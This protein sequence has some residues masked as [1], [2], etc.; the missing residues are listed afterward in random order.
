MNSDL[1]GNAPDT[2]PAALLIIDMINDLE[3][4]DADEDAENIKEPAIAAA[5]RIA[6]LKTRCKAEG[7]PVIYCNDNFG[8][9][10][11]DFHEV[12]DR[13]L[14]DGVRGEALAK[15]LKPEKDDYFIL[16]PKHSAFFET[17]LETLLK[18]LGVDTII[19][20]GITGDICLLL[21]A[22]DA[23]M[24]DY[25]ILVPHD[26]TASVTREENEHALNYMQRVLKADIT[27][28]TDADVASLMAA[29]TRERSRRRE[30]AGTQS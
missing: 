22:S 29:D 18:Y 5:H 15:T 19:L 13:V 17:T 7:M 9:W 21:T 25:K 2:A 10:R 11:S 26:C 12:V 28:S 27:T 23:F 8:R 3:W 6:E 1:H 14:H 24:R 20:T 30:T 16:K 4:P